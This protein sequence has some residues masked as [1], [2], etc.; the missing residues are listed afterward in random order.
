MLK[1]ILITAALALSAVDARAQAPL[2][3][4]DYSK[5]DT[6]LCRPGR[7]DACAVPQDATIITADGKMRRE[8]Y[9]AA[10]NPP[11][12]CFYVY[13]TVSVEPTANSDLLITAAERNV[14]R[15]QFAR[16][17]TQCRQ[18]APMYRQVTLTALIAILSGKP[19]PVDRLLAYNDVLAA[20]NYYLAH[21]NNGRGVVLVG[22]SQGSGVLT[23]LIKDEIDGKPVQG[24]IISAILMGTSLPVPKGADVGGAFTHIPVCR[25][26]QQVG[27]V[28]AY[29]DFRDNV[30]P[31]ATSR[32]AHAPEGMQAVC[33]NPAA[34]AGGSGML[35]AYL[36]SGKITGGE[37]VAPQPFDWTTP[38]KPVDTPF[39]KVP[40]LLSAECVQ[41]EHGSYLAVTLHP[42]P[43]GARVND[44]SGD[45][46]IAGKVAEDWGLHLIDANLTM[47]NLIVLV[48]DESKA[49][50]A[51]RK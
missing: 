9:R 39:V 4:A 5:P 3:E 18:F 27:C 17:G 15:A 45:V 32:F 13:P 30:P 37:N 33:A 40:G 19:M 34:L 23:Q 36:S 26:N 38:P 50:L 29:A 1:M 21:D 11:I 2:A 35:D 46:M 20:W 42:T 12:D 28:I 47:G 6:W 22:H 25:S 10:K 14:V 51:R 24:K 48:A 8:S 16:F 7:Q 49:Y 41:N 44:I 31:P 43:G